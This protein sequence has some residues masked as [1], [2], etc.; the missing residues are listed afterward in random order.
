M[1]NF[2]TA[3]AIL[4]PDATLQRS[5]QRR[6]RFYP[7]TCADDRRGRCHEQAAYPADLLIRSLSARSPAAYP[8]TSPPLRTRRASGIRRNTW[9]TA[10]RS[11]WRQKSRAIFPGRLAIRRRAPDTYGSCATSPATTTA[12]ADR[13]ARR[14]RY[15][16]PGTGPYPGEICQAGT[17]ADAGAEPVFRRT[18]TPA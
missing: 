4:E 6:P 16:L 2:Q 13:A 17:D 14:K 12:H 11:A 1:R 5:R 18:F 8:A 10:W 15:Y 3:A 7:P 9:S